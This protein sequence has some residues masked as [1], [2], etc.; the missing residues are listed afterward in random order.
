M[1]ARRFG[2]GLLLVFA[3]AVGTIGCGDDGGGGAD[4]GVDGGADGGGAS[5]NSFADAEAIAEALG[6]ADTFQRNESEPLAGPVPASAGYCDGDGSPS[7]E[8]YG[9]PDD[10]DEIRRDLP[11]VGCSILQGFG[12]DRL[13]TVVGANWMVTPSGEP[14]AELAGRLASMLDGEVIDVDCA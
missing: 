9:S 7:F 10:V 1:R 11:T 2:I 6:C 13:V 14:D 5:V 8:V 3:G 4:G 12:I